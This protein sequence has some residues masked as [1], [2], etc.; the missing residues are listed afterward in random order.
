MAPAR[1]T[2]YLIM[3]KIVCE[4]G[5]YKQLYAISSKMEEIFTARK[6]LIG[7]M[8]A[9]I[10]Q[11]ISAFH[12][13]GVD[14]AVPLMKEALSLAEVDGCYVTLAENT[15]E[16]ISILEKMDEPS[17]KIVKELA[18]KYLE[19][20]E[21][22]RRKRKP[23]NQLTKRECEVMDLVCDGFT[24]EAIGKILYVSMSTVKKHTAAAYEKLGVNKKAD[25]IAAYR[26]ITR[27]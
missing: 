22:F 10:Y 15:N 1:D 19:S 3:G 5:D 13:K 7:V 25:A 12:L 8:V 20:K 24:A 17:A 9:K 21:I 26:K 23:V 27:K 6:N 18:E 14:E 11:S 4:R 16:I 2:A